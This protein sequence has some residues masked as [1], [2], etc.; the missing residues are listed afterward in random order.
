[1]LNPFLLLF[2]LLLL[3]CGLSVLSFAKGPIAKIGLVIGFWV[4]FGFTAFL[5]GVA[6]DFLY[7]DSNLDDWMT[8]VGPALVLVPFA[9]MLYNMERPRRKRATAM[10]IAGLGSLPITVLWLLASGIF[11]T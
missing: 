7:H 9:L 11:Q 4:F 1:M 5:N 10:I 6:M 8:F 3:V 2:A